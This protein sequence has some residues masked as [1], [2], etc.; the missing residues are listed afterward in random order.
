VQS[1]SRRALLTALVSSG[2]ASGLTFLVLRRH[3]ADRARASSDGRKDSVAE[4]LP[5]E[6]LQALSAAEYAVLVAAS[7][8]IFPRDATPGATDL[9]VAFYVDAA[10]AGDVAPGW[11]DGFREGLRRLDAESIA[12]LSVRFSE[13]TSDAREALLADWAGREEGSNPGDARFVRQLVTATL[14]G[15]L[16]DPVHRGNAREAGWRSLGFRPDPFAPSARA[17]R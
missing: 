8:H 9:G 12:R 17:A 14:E 16:C 2:L 15:A 10:L 1:P 6:D 5:E 11:S 7:E 4:A 3:P 13:A